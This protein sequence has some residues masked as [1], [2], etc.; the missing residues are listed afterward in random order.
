MPRK[1]AERRRDRRR[2]SESRSASNASTVSPA[3]AVAHGAA[4]NG[5]TALLVVGRN[6]IPLIGV[7]VFDW[8]AG[9]VILDYWFDGLTALA[10]IIAVLVPLAMR[11]SGVGS[12]HGIRLLQG[13]WTWVLL[14][15]LLGIPFWLALAV[16]SPMIF[17]GDVIEPLRTSVTPWIALLAIAAMNVGVAMRR[18]YA[19]LAGAALTQALRWDVY[20]LLLRALAMV[21]VAAHL[22]AI[23]TVVAIGVAITWMELYPR[24]ALGLVHGDPDALWRLKSD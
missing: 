19:D 1:N 14:V 22:P 8:P 15:A 7:L 23:L 3:I 18:G 5:I 10:A 2:E 21:F 16:L 4:T 11:D 6:A 24:R 13:L 17:V 9:L 20:L 12:S